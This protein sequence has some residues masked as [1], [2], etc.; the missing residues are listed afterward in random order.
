MH[1]ETYSDNV[2]LNGNIAIKVGI[3]SYFVAE[4][5]MVRH[6]K[7]NVEARA[8]YGDEAQ[9]EALTRIR[10]GEPL[11]RVSK[12]LSIP[13]RTIR[14]HRDEHVKNPG[15]VQMGAKSILSMP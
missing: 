6:Y 13:A 10:Q 11:L 15:V 8:T 9:R 12:R 14:R 5:R 7:R 4:E 2:V 1:T 3:A